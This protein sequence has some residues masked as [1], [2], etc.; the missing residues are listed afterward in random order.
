M[1]DSAAEAALDDLA[2]RRR[3]EELSALAA[4]RIGAAVGTVEAWLDRTA[5][6]VDRGEELRTLS[7]QM[8]VEIAR[9]ANIVLEV[10]ASACGSVPFVA[11][12]GLD[13]ARR[14]LQTFLLQHR[15]DPLLVRTGREELERR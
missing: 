7:V 13:R 4:G 2:T 15:L 3:G 1:I 6:A 8:R 9:A 11:G 14:D 10:A 5:A 12:S